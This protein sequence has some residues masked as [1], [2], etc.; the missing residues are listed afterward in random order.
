MV[1]T[2][3]VARVVAVEVVGQTDQMK[4]KARVRLVEALVKC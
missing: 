4:S 1:K 2:E 3:Q